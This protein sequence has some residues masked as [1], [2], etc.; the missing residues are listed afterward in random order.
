[1]NAFLQSLRLFGLN[2]SSLLASLIVMLAVSGSTTFAQQTAQF[3]KIKPQYQTFEWNSLQ[4]HGFDIYY[5]EGGEYLAQYAG[6]VLEEATKTTQRTLGFVWNERFPAVIYNSPNESQQTNAQDGLLARGAGGINELRRNRMVIAFRGDWADFRLALRRELALSMVNLLYYG[7]NLPSPINGQFDLPVWFG[8][9]LAEF[10]SNEGIDAETDMLVRDLITSEQFTS[11]NALDGYARVKMG[12]MLFGYIQEKFGPSKISELITRARGMGTV[13]GAFRATFGVNVEGFTTLWKRDLRSMYAADGARYEDIEKISQRL[14]DASKDGSPMFT[15][16]L[17]APA[18]SPNGERLAYL[19][20]RENGVWSVYLQDMRAKRQDKLDRIAT[21]GRALDTKSTSLDG[22]SLSWKPDNTQIAYITQ[23]G[24]VEGISLVNVQNGSIQR[25]DLNFKIIRSLAFA[26]D[27][28]NI[29]FVAVENEMPNIYLYD[30]AAKKLSKLTKDIF[31]ENL[32]TWS[33]DGKNLFFVSDRAGILSTNVSSAT[34]SIWDHDTRSSDVYALN[35]A[36]KKIE[37]LTNDSFVRKVGL[38]IS[39]DAKKLLI[40]SDR[41]GITNLYEWNVASKTLIPKTNLLTGVGAIGLAKDGSRLALTSIRKGG[42]GLFVLPSPFDRKIKEP[43]PTELRKQA[44]ER[45]SVAEKALG[46]TPAATQAVTG[47]GSIDTSIVAGVSNPT[48]QSAPTSDDTPRSYGKFDV[49]FSRQKMIEPDPDVVARTASQLVAEQNDYSKPGKLPSLPLQY[50]LEFHSYSFG[51]SFDTFFGGQS[52]DGGQQFLGNA[53]LSG[54]AIWQDIMGNN[55]LHIS[56]NVMFDLNN[57]DFAA[58]YT[59]LPE[60]LDYEFSLFRTGRRSVVFDSQT[61]SLLWARL[62]YWGGSGKIMLPLGA[63]MRLEGKLS[64]LNS[65][66]ESVDPSF[67]RTFNR[68]EFLVVPETRFVLDNT[69]TGFFGSIS[70]ARGFAKVEA[71]PGLAGLTFVRAM[72]DYRQ[73][74]PIKN[75]G[76][77]AARVSAGTNVG[78]TPQLFYAGGQENL[79]LGRTLASDF[80]PFNRAEDLLFVQTVMPLRG[81]PLFSASGNNFV[82]ANVEARFSLLQPDGSN[83]MLSNILNG[84]QAVAFVD[85]GSTWTNTLRLAIPAPKFDAFGNP[86]GYEGGDL[87][88]SVGIGLRTYLLGQWPVKVDLA[89]QN[90]QTGLSAPR[91][92][93]GFGYNF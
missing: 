38:A 13:D 35:L 87:L 48:S 47:Q 49:D 14:T 78:S 19:S 22:L 65:I 57:T 7:A 15:S 46:R 75:I 34:Y 33:P 39:A 41:N 86:A 62:S 63:G 61:R 17:A 10:M 43:E 79:I 50:N 92:L 81:F 45:E 85:A 76:V 36:T 2:V 18:F 24:G 20:A 64:V 59:Y 1:M 60:L 84:L 4:S 27:G 77:I 12:Q 8:E 32:P 73:Y 90:L 31:T 6:V 58:T 93:V 40:V 30:V 68:S 51:P 55:R 26:P 16:I 3:G 44:L 72:G 56:A 66:K 42:A 54:Q 91:F 29:A 67:S 70:G 28:K 23:G 52:N 82:S 83:N 5:H 88:M 21:T 89:F 74:I 11:M 71:V 80:L 69:E 53:A 37:R 25:L 9:G